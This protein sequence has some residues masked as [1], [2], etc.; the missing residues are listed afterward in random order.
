[1][2]VL[3]VVRVVVVDNWS[4]PLQTYCLL[5]SAMPALPSP[6]KSTP[7][8]NTH[9][10]GLLTSTNDVTLLSSATL[11]FAS[12]KHSVESP[13]SSYPCEAHVSPTPSKT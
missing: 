10:N 11:L 3:N 9:A 2:D 7:Y 13:I 12:P 8:W 6:K 1:M 4:G 5:T